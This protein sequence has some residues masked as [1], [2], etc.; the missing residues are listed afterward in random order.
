MEIFW[1]MII[2]LA[3][4]FVVGCLDEERRNKKYALILYKE[5]EE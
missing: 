2:S 4:G 3:V 5:G 1:T